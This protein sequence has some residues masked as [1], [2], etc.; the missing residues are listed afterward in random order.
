MIRCN[1]VCFYENWFTLSEK[2]MGINQ[3][4]KG[5]EG[6]INELREECLRFGYDEKGKL[7][8]KREG[9]N[10]DLIIAFMQALYWSNEV[11]TA[12]IISP[13]NQYKF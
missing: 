2:Y 3:L 6:V 13:Y 1:Q 5:K 11:E 7:T 8:A 9:M 10:D 12:P 4:N